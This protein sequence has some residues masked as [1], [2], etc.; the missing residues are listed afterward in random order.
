MAIKK[1][2]LIDFLKDASVAKRRATRRAWRCLALPVVLA[3]TI[4]AA[5]AQVATDADPTDSA[6]NRPQVAYDASGVSFGNVVV[7]PAISLTGGYDSNVFA[8]ENDVVADSSVTVTPKVRAEFNHP[9][10]SLSFSGQA[11][12]RRYAQLTRQNDEQYNVD[13][14]GALEVSRSTNIAGNFTWARST[15]TR[16]TFENGLQ[17]GDPLREEEMTGSLTGVQRFNRLQVRGTLSA[18]WFRFDNIRLD[19]GTTV[20]QSFRNGSKLSGALRLA[21]EI[22][23][24]FSLTAQSN[25]DRY[26]YLDSRPLRYRDAVGSTF[27]AGGR[28][29]ITRLLI[30]D[31]GAGVRHYNFKNPLFPDISGLALNGRVRWYPTPLVTLRFDLSQ[32]VSTSSFDSVSAVTVTSAGLSGDYEFRRNVIVSGSITESHEQYGGIGLSSDYLSLTG[33]VNWKLN[34]WL[35]LD[36]QTTY[37]SRTRSAPGLIPIF[38]AWRF[39]V[40]LTFAK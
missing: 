8:R 17:V 10:A 6:G 33:H 22:S 36:G 34:R 24:R 21:Y 20:D 13:L 26:D 5:S 1:L 11:R 25:I 35:R 15:V 12:I 14:Q 16:G 3:G 28:Y 29:E 2:L 40:S 30:V 37:E 7:F 27:T 32:S 9:G 18:D 38:N 39:Q 23:P 31:L 4:S 19:D